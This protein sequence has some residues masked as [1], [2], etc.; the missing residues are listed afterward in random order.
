MINGAAGTVANFGTVQETGTV[1]AVALTAGGT[2][3]NGAVGATTAL[4]TGTGTGVRHQCSGYRDQF[5]R[6]H[7]HFRF[8]WK[9]YRS[10]RRQ[11]PEFWDAEEYRSRRFGSLSARK[12]KRHQRQDRIDLWS[13]NRHFRPRRYRDNH[14][15]RHDREFRT[16]SLLHRRRQHNEP[17]RRLDRRKLFRRRQPRRRAYGDELRFDRVDGYQR[18][19]LPAR[20]RQRHQRRRG[21]DR[22]Q[23]RRHRARAAGRRRPTAASSRG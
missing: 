9:C 4:I 3:T 18:R 5:R 6:N 23:R 10:E 19:H 20:R 13:R 12:R 8:V 1:S 17:S 21:D 14:E 2:V 7:R 11:C 22:R 15:F 16:G